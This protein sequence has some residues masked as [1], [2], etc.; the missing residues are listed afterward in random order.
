MG[1][2]SNYKYVCQVFSSTLLWDIPNNFML[3]VLT[4]STVELRGAD[5]LKEMDET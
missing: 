1:Q 4:L 2:D 5:L 3:N